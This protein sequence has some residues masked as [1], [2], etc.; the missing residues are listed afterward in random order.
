MKLSVSVCQLLHDDD[1][2]NN[3]DDNDDFLPCL[4][5]SLANPTIIIYIHFISYHRSSSS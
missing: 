4:I 3:D 2:N 1:N 5:M